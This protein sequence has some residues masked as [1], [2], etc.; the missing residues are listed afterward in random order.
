MTG[1]YDE[2]EPVRCSCGRLLHDPESRARGQGPVCYRRLHPPP[3]RP[4]RATTT[5]ARP[6]PGQDELPLTDQLGLW[7]L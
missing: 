7:S 4:G 3:A 5:V 6:G 1:P 2:E